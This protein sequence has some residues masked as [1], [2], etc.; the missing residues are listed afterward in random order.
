MLKIGITGGIGSGKTTVANLFARLGVPVFFADSET[1]MLQ[2]TDATLRAELIAAFGAQTYQPD[3][4]LNR[5]Y[6]AQLV[7][8]DKAALQKINSIVH[9]AVARHF[10][11]WC[12]A[13]QTHAYILKEA[14][15][16]FESGSNNGLD[17]VIAV[18]APET[19]RIERVMQRDNITEQDVRK[20]MAN[21]WPEA[22]KLKRANWII[23]NDGR[24]L[25]PQ[26]EEIHHTLM[27]LS[28]AGR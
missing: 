27:A 14:A 15:I 2:N 20:R 17:G 22:E 5:T 23:Y 13:H 1:R 8:A 9:P 11:V 25:E 28:K 18:T 24:A 26:V 4:S 6:L 19:L 10:T 12:Q 16:L 7:F 3:G 21:Q